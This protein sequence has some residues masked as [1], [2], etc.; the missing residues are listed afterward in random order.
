MI[1]VR[2][3]AKIYLVCK[4]NYKKYKKNQMKINKDYQKLII[5]WKL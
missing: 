1:N 2:L 5:L 3:Q 4:K